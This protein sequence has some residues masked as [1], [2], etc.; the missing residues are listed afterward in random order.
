MQRASRENLEINPMQSN[1]REI[2]RVSIT[3]AR[4][5]RMVGVE[6]NCKTSRNNPMQRNGVCSPDGAP[7]GPEPGRAKFRES[8]SRRSP[9]HFAAACGG[10]L[11]TGYG[12]NAS[13]WNNPMQRRGTENGGITPCKGGRVRARSQSRNNPMQRTGRKPRNNPMQRKRGLQPGW[14]ARRRQGY[15]RFT[16]QPAEAQ[17][18][19]EHRP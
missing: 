15:G 9:P 2:V 8:M 10:T 5:L 18:R 6:R 13:S 4:T 12:A 16:S 3:I 14:S 11:H 17:R 19:R 7:A 1:A